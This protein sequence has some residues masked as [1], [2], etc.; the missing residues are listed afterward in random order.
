MIW[1]EEKDIPKLKERFSKSLKDYVSINIFTHGDDCKSC[2]DAIS[3][4][5]ELSSFDSRFKLEKH[6]IGS[7][8]SNK[9]GIKDGP[10]IILISEHFPEGNVRYYGIP[11]GHEFLVLMEDLE[12]FSSGK[13]NLSSSV[14]EKI[15]SINQPTEIKIYTTPMCQYCPAMVKSAHRFAMINKNITGSMIA[16]MEF[17]SE[18]DEVGVMQVPHITVNGE[19]LYVG[20]LPEETFAS[21][22]QDSLA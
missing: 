7:E 16:T 17:S 12:A 10:V 14:V 6:S 18:A 13:V 11:S 2:S 1:F 8:I 3:L 4:M 19:T 22:I 20:S 5:E 15:K 21:Y 9:Y